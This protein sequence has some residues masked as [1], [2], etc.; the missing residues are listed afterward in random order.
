M[1]FKVFKV[2]ESDIN[3]ADPQGVGPSED[4]RPSEPGICCLN[5][6]LI[7]RF[8]SCNESDMWEISGFISDHESRGHKVYFGIFDG[9]NL[10]LKGIIQGL[11]Q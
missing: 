6:A 10:I 5:C 8:D 1:T 11:R 7:A 4:V 2:S 3:P 9:D